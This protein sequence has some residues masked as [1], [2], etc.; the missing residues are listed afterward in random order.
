M[1]GRME[2]QLAVIDTDLRK[3]NDTSN[4]FPVSSKVKKMS[5]TFYF[6]ILMISIWGLSSEPVQISKFENQNYQEVTRFSCLGSSAGLPADWVE[7]HNF[8]LCPRSEDAVGEGHIPNGRATRPTW[9][10]RGRSLKK[11]ADP[12]T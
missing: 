12:P 9:K 7:Y 4:E 10:G 8:R 6:I 5:Y 3:E 1:N 11:E 2:K